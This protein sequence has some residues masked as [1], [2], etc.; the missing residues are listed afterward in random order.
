MTIASLLRDAGY[1]TAMVGKWHLGF[2]ENG[3]DKPLPGP[4]DPAGQLYHLLDD[5]A[6]TINR[7]AEQPE[8][9]KRLQAEMRGI[10]AAPTFCSDG[11]PA[12]A[13]R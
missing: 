4:G 11:R 6:E 10:I 9:V 3:Y 7:F 1:A 5:P 12:S 13:Y 8:I 2:A